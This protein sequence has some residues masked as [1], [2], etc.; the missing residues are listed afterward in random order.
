MDWSDPL[1][2]FALVQTV[3]MYV[4]LIFFIA[5]HMR[6]HRGDARGMYAPI[7]EMFGAQ[8]DGEDEEEDEAGE[9]EGDKDGQGEAEEKKSKNNSKKNK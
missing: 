1:R 4:A 8:E 9:G 3:V 7:D 2:L 5:R 6:T